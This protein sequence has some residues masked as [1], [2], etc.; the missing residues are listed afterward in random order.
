MANQVDFKIAPSDQFSVYSPS[1]RSEKTITYFTLLSKLRGDILAVSQEED[2][3]DIVAAYYS[4]TGGTQ[5][6]HLVKAD[7]SE[8]TAS[9]STATSTENQNASTGILVGGELTSSIGGTTFSVSSGVG[10]IVSQV[11]TPSGV[12]TI[13]TPIS[14]DAFTSITPTNLT[15]QPF[16]YVYIDSSG[17]LQQQATPFSDAQYKNSII[18][19]HVCHIDLATINL[20]TSDQNVAYGTP[21]RLLELI[22]TF[23]PIKKEG[24][25]LSANGSNLQVNRSAG[26]GFI[27]GSNYQTDQFDPDKIVISA[28]T[29]SLLCRIY[30]NGSGGYVF[31]NN[32]GSYYANVDAT[33]YDNGSGTLQ[34]V[35]NNQW[36]IQRLYT[37]PSA[38]DDIICYYGVQIYNSQ[39]DAIDNI[40]YEPFSEAPIT[41]LNSI[42]LGYLV[43]RGGA[44][45]LSSLG[46]A[47]FIQAGLFRG[48]GSG[49]G[50]TTNLKLE[51]L[52]DVVITS[53]QNQDFLFYNSLSQEWQNVAVGA[54][55]TIAVSGQSNI[56]ADNYAD[57][58]NID[59]GTGI[60][61][62]T[63]ASTDTLTI[64]NSAP[65]QVVSLTGA[66]TTVVTGTYPSFTITSN[67]EFDGT[68]TSVATTAPITGGTITTTGTIGITQSGTASDG[69][70]SSADWNT[71]NGK[72]P[73]LTKGNLTETTSSVLT[74]TGGT[75]A[76]IGTGTS[77]QV[78]QSSSSSNGYLSSTDWTTFNGKQDAITLTTTGTSGAATLVGSTLNIPDYTEQ[79]SGTVTSVSTTAPITGGPITT[80]GTIGITQS[81]A[82]S[83]G[84]LSSADWTTFNSKEP[85]LTKGNLTEAT[86]AVLTITGGTGAVIGTGTTI[87]VT[88]A[89]STTSGYLSSTDW[90][91]FNGKASNS[92]TTIA[93]ATQ[94][95]IVADSAT[96][97]LTI[98]AGTG[99]SITTDA[100]TDTLTISATGSGGTVTS[101]STT[102]PITGGPI[103]GTGTIAITQSGT[104]S[105]GYLSSA[106]WNTFNGK[107]NAITLTTTGS[108]GAATLV[109]A[110]LN[111]PQYTDQ[112]TGTV[113]SV[114]ALT[115]GTTGTDLSSTVANGTTTPVI[116]L[117]VPTASATNRGA[118][119]SG[120]WTTFNGK[121]NAI[122]LTTTG[123][124]GAATFAS[125]ILNIPQYTDQYTGTVTSVDLTAG[126]GISVSG[127][128]II[129]SG[130]ITV[131][132]TDRG[133]SQNIFKNIAVSGQ[134]TII[135]DNNDD[136][137]NV[138][139]GDRIDITTTAASDILTIT[140]GSA[141]GADF[142]TAEDFRD[143]VIA[144]GGTFEALGE[145]AIAIGSL[146]DIASPA[147]TDYSD[148]F[149]L[150]NIA[151]DEFGH[152][153][154]IGATDLDERYAQVAFK[155]IAVSGQLTI[156]ADSTDDTLNIASGYGIA[157]T[158]DDT[159][160]TLTIAVDPLA[161]TVALSNQLLLKA[162]TTLYGV[163]SSW[164]VISLDATSVQL[165]AT[166]DSDGVYSSNIAFVTISIS[167]TASEASFVSIGIRL[168]NATQSAVITDST[169]TWSGYLDA[170]GF[171]TATTLFTYHIP[172]E[173]YVAAGDVIRVEVIDLNSLSPKIG[174]ASYTLFAG[175]GPF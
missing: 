76:V 16:T 163:T 107:Q 173:E 55:K 41:A 167:N 11:A 24:L 158:T 45:S 89:S 172:I 164:A 171:D 157:L 28:K 23:G 128:P 72:E 59:S 35:N 134:S 5:T 47:T 7:G 174:Q 68:V 143:R 52:S 92:F 48:L 103:T 63:N 81:G 115:L 4:N 8:V 97:T 111:I 19:G 88:Q 69:Y 36:T 83:D 140:H 62:T 149:V 65:D 60:S 9:Y 127:G 84:Y 105:D 148:G 29:P 135:A 17:V 169:M 15:T 99:V 12:S 150:Q 154:G 31:D 95:N 136:T 13:I 129:T 91:T 160:D 141:T 118:L 159:T 21:T 70:L 90:T 30:R 73:A 110:T 86:S 147:S 114:A 44:S 113:T 168:Y 80:T 20:V 82:A 101:I 40:P 124:S 117:N 77:I 175:P 34:T 145:V 43:V 94:T 54:F 156:E 139:A 162:S 64:T 165:S 6:L 14:W 85:A 132:N 102:A 10:Q 49:G 27:I 50:S 33:K 166:V 100:L 119:S 67:D 57:T 26:E 155:N 25:T 18:I 112:F 96:D 151:V 109:G 133:S 56:V 38:P 122:T 104:A 58:L 137:L 93:V 2:P 39:G 71:F 142:T 42:F 98:A 79:Y 22:Q 120:D 53:P 61:L 121:Q 87:Q 161:P 125:N 130:S 153:L 3:N 66:G 46:D 126:T 37:F 78:S 146:E 106:D 138:V 32:S 108:S 51:D 144:D 123:T 131:N 75:N 116:T 170:D 74:I 1:T 152:V